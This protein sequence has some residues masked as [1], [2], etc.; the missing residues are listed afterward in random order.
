MSKKNKKT[1]SKKA[2]IIIAI[3][4]VALVITGIVTAIILVNIKRFNM[5]ANIKADYNNHTRFISVGQDIGSIYQ[6]VDATIYNNGVQI[7]KNHNQK[8]GLF[9]YISNSLVLDTNYQISVL[10]ANTEDNQTLFKAVKFGKTNCIQ[11]ANQ[12]GQI[13]NIT[14]IDEENNKTYAYIKSKS[15]ELTERNNKINS[16][17]SRD[18]KDVKVQ[19]KDIEYSRTYHK[20]GK[21]TYEVWT[22]TTTDDLTYE[23]FYKVEGSNRELVQTINNSIGVNIDTENTSVYVLSNGTPILTET[24]HTYFE[25]KLTNLEIITYDI[26]FNKK[27]SAVISSDILNSVNISFTVGDNLYLQCLTPAT[28]DK[29]DFADTQNK[30]GSIFNDNIYY[31]VTTYKIAYKNAKLSE[32]DFNF[33]ITNTETSFNKD[34]ILLNAYNIESKALS[35]SQILLANEK[36][37]TKNLN[38]SFNTIQQI[39]KDR[40]L[41]STDGTSNFYL[42]DGGYNLIRQLENATSIFTTEDAIVYE[43]QE[44]YSYVCNLDGVI[45]KKVTTDSIQDVNN[46]KYYVRTIEKDVNG[47]SQTEYYLERQGKMQDNPIHTEIS[48]VSDY[49]YGDHTYVDFQIVTT[50]DYT[51]IV[52]IRKTGATTYT[53]DF[54]NIDGVLLNSVAN[55]STNYQSITLVKSYD[56]NVLINFY[57]SVYLLDR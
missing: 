19:I 40:Y 49:N 23:N 45:L 12:N 56:N 48:G 34:T 41:A 47:I 1:L 33:V 27:G 38:Y 7:V 37:Q 29:H 5:T 42:I 18:F 35:D 39:T 20:D 53:Y 24:K 52:R 2:K 6:K 21:Y 9:S 57:G 31:N 50:D 28:E 55:V 44:M 16:N 32:V 8:H 11:I 10:S 4:S 30:L 46:D 13:L 17:I 54:Y 43:T 15:V 36:L 51:L 25:S 14:Q 26:N 3:V 22:I